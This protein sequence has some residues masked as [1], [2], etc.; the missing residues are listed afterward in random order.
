MSFLFFLIPLIYLPSLFNFFSGDDWFHLRIT[1]INSF[2]QF[3]NFFSFIHTPQSAS[4]YRP[5]ST[6]L[7]FYVFQTLFG[8]SAFP[9]YLFVLVAFAFS[10]YLIFS[11]VKTVL[12]D[13]RLAIISTIIYGISVSNFTRIYFLSAFQEISLVTFSLL[14]LSAHFK[15]KNSKYIYLILAL[16]SK[17]T[18]VVLPVL[19]L[20]M[21]Y[22]FKKINIKK[23]IFT[24][25]II[26]IYL[27]LRLFIFGIASGD[28]YGW[29]FSPLKAIN[30]SIWYFLWSI[31]SPELLVDYI[32]PGFVPIQRFFSDFQ[33]TWQVI[34]FPLLSLIILIIAAAFSYLRKLKQIYKPFYFSILFFVLTLLP[35][36]FLP[37]HK[38]ALELGLP[39]IGLSLGLAIIFKDSKFLYL[40]LIIFVSYNLAMNVITYNKHYSVTRAKIS[41]LVYEYINKNYPTYPSGKYFY[42]TNSKDSQVTAFGQSKQVALALS[43]SDFF[44]VYYHNDSIKVYY[45]DLGGQRPKDETEIDIPSQQFLSISE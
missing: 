18:A 43:T 37:Q 45:E 36:I 14:F 33:Q 23:Y 4:F 13:N 29:D 16:L 25:V 17:E 2:P 9:Y 8:L 31:G 7:F 20:L 11:F 30:T 24:I 1:R 42:F 28:G 39:L 41:K 32:G 27:F 5:L 26:L 6:Q 34:I 40:F 35:V 10:L 15:N 38:F 12:N 3:A 22:C 21:D 19:A 44:K